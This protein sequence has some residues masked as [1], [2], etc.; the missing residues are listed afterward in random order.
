MQTPHWRERLPGTGSFGKKMTPAV[1]GAITGLFLQLAIGPV[2]FLVLGITLTSNFINGFSA[3][4]AVTIVDFLFIFLSLF[5]VG[6]LISGRRKR[7]WTAI[8]SIL[9]ILFGIMQIHQGLGAIAGLE[10][11]PAS[12]WTPLS[13]FS[14]SFALTASSPLTIVFW[15]S[16]FSAKASEYQYDQR[17]LMFFGMGAGLSTLFFLSTTMFAIS[18]CTTSIPSIAWRAANC[19]V[20][21]TLV[22]YGITRLVKT[23]PPGDR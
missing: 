9:L 15:G 14:G 17:Q 10:S 7:L 18:L 8:S 19:L 21:I 22:Y 11:L 23:F 12:F 20:G 4:L 1:N 2:F 13:S 5:G 3:I 16:V 6:R